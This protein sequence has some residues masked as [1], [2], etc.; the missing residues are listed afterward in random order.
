MSQYSHTLDSNSQTVAE[1]A[2]SQ[3]AALSVFTKYNIDY[4]C[5]G[6][7]SLEDAC[8]PL[9]LNPETIRQEIFSAPPQQSSLSL[10]AENWSVSLL[11]DYIVQKHHRYVRR[12]IPEIEALLDKVCAAHGE[13]SVELLS[14]QQDFAD[15]AQEL[16]NHM[17][18]EE[19]ALFP[20]LKRLETS[21][22]PAHPL[23]DSLKAPISMME[24]EHAVAGDLMNSIRTLSNY[25]SAP[26]FA[27]PTY[28]IT[29]QKLK[30]FDDDLMTHVHLENNILF[31]KAKRVAEN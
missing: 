17:T 27:C 24:H 2:I 19:V 18:K 26:E 22:H 23:A 1:L 4:C 8:V 7:R 11:V 5:G 20:A 9:G 15:L 29:Y 6:N 21:G 3:P 31:Q 28:R 14:I 10:Q 12:A 25:Y 30:Q 16:L 13:D